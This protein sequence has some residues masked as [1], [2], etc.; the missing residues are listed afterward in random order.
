MDE[1]TRLRLAQ[2]KARSLGFDLE[3]VGNIYKLSMTRH[4]QYP[5][6]ISERLDLIEAQLGVVVRELAKGKAI[7]AHNADPHSGKTPAGSSEAASN[8]DVTKEWARIRARQKLDAEINLFRIDNKGQGL[9][10]V[11]IQY[12]GYCG[13]CADFSWRAGR[14]VVALMNPWGSDLKIP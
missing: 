10:L 8:D 12:S 13:S 14:L 2:Q 4:T 5:P 9:G 7:D 11:I 1:D 6:M 3:K